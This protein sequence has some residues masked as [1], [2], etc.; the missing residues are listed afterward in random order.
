M[1]AIATQRISWDIPKG[2]LIPNQKLS[3]SGHQMIGTSN[4]RYLANVSPTD[5]AIVITQRD[6]FDDIAA[7]LILEPGRG[8]TTTF[9]FRN[10]NDPID[11]RPFLWSETFTD[12]RVPEK[13]PQYDPRE[14]LPTCSEV[15]NALC[16]IDTGRKVTTNCLIAE[17]YQGCLNVLQLLQAE[18]QRVSI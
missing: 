11:G 14:G 6:D 16:Q 13:F 2:L 7:K 8:N 15:S 1:A 9:E 4:A 18:A 3:L 17:H 5:K 10:P 12:S